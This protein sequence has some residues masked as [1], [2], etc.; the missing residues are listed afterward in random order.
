MNDHAKEMTLMELCEAVDLPEQTFIQMVEHGIVEPS[1]DEP[2]QWSFDLTMVSIV[3]RATRLHRDLELDWAAV[4][5]VENLIEEREQ[6]IMENE[7]LTQRLQR[8]LSD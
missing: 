2:A 8:F 3:R 6:L 7:V 5:L 4:A 1:G